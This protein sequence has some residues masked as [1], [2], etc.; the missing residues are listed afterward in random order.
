MK[1]MFFVVISVLIC[2]ISFGQKY[3]TKETSDLRYNKVSDNVNPYT[4]IFTQH[5]TDSVAK[6][7]ADSVKSTISLGSTWKENTMEK[8]LR[9]LGSDMISQTFGIS[10][11]G[12]NSITLSNGYVYYIAV[13]L[14]RDTTITG[15]STML[16]T[17]GAFTPTY[18][19][20][21]ICLPQGGNFVKVRETAT[22]GAIWT[23]TADTQIKVALSSPYSASKGMIYI[24]FIYYGTGQTTAPKIYSGGNRVASVNNGVAYGTTY[25]LCSQITSQ[26]AIPNSVASST[27]VGITGVPFVKVY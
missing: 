10:D 9:L 14:K 23:A 22:N 6:A 27:A 12:Q 19:S 26:T 7:K 1:K 8:G 21:A 15:V 24:A 4:I 25:K 3:F 18:N 20:F 17:A 16:Q 5:Q 13:E 2:S 11:V